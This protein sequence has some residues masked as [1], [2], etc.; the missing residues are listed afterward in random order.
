MLGRS[1]TEPSLFYSSARLYGAP[2]YAAL[3]NRPA[4][5]CKFSVVALKGQGDLDAAGEQPVSRA[6]RISHDAHI[7]LLSDSGILESDRCD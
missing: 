2:R 5:S 4:R 3:V 1:N 6:D 7:E